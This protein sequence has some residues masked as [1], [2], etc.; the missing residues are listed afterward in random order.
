MRPTSASFVKLYLGYS[1]TAKPDDVRQ[2]TLDEMDRQW[3]YMKLSIFG[4]TALSTFC[5]GGVCLAHLAYT[6]AHTEVAEFAR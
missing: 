2:C 1:K 3:H 4:F 6:A 5:C